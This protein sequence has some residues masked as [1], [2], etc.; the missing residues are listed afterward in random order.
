MFWIV[1]GLITAAVAWYFMNQAR[2][3]L[4]VCK[5]LG[6]LPIQQPS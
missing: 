6:L 2:L 3:T 5:R 1:I 4:E